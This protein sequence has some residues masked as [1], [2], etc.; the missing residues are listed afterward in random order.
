MSQFPHICAVVRAGMFSCLNIIRI[1]VLEG[2]EKGG[3]WGAK[4]KEGSRQLVHVKW[5]K[6]FCK[7]LEKMFF[8]CILRIN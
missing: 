1:I 3:G 4:R 5:D 2:K 7:T 6:L 8:F